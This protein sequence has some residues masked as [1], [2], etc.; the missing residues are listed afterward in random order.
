MTPLLKKVLSKKVERRIA[1]AATMLMGLALSGCPQLL[2]DDFQ[3]DAVRASGS[4]AQGEASGAGGAGAN[5]AS[6]KSDASTDAGIAASQSRLPDA[7][8]GLI[9]DGSVLQACG[10]GC[11]ECCADEHCDDADPCT[12]DSCGQGGQCQV[13]ARCESGGL[14]CEGVGCSECCGDADCGGALAV[15]QGGVCVAECTLPETACGF[16]CA[17]LDTAADHCG[18]CN[19]SC[20]LNRACVAG[21]CSPSWQGVAASP[22]ALSAREFSGHG[23]MGEKVFVFGGRNSFGIA[24]A[25]GAVYDPALDSWSMLPNAGRPS[26]RLLPT[27][28]WTGSVMIV[29]GGG[30]SA[31][32]TEFSDGAMYNPVTDQWTAMATVGA[33]SN[34][35]GAHGFWTGSEMIL[36]GGLNGGALSERTIVYLFDPVGNSWRAGSGEGGEEIEGVLNPVVEW[37]GTYLYLNGGVNGTSERDIFFEYDPVTQLWVKRI[38]GPTDREGAFGKWNG[39]QLVVWGGLNDG[40]VLS[41]GRRWS[42]TASGGFWDDIAGNATRARSSTANEAGW[43][44]A[45]GNSRLLLLGGANDSG[46]HFSNTM[47]YDGVANAWS[48]LDSWPSGEFHLGGVGVWTGREFVLWGGRRTGAEI[49]TT[50]GERFRP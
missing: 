14:C 37:S 47:T 32:T 7:V 38:G 31:N 49:L 17:N 13:S 19:Y 1:C 20:G 43:V 34:R 15:C 23:A 50:T 8:G 3:A 45:I 6:S 40:D 21:S 2:K 48:N 22:S 25:N 42:P 18:L 24:L 28:V 11:Q 44:A 4:G 9:C 12:V 33:P 35:R 29:W 10:G 27:V 30:N 16:T 26:A 5:L 36:W 46:G 39:S 41:D